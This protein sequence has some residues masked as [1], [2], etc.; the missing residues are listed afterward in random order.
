[1]FS[2]PSTHK[3][4]LS[5]S[6]DCGVEDTT[7]FLFSEDDENLRTKIKNAISDSKKN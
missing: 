7:A 4:E 1:M 6:V 3:L 5:K 2:E